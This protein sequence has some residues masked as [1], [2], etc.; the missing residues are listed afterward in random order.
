MAFSSWPSP[1]IRSRLDP[2]LEAELKQIRSDGFARDAEEHEAGIKCLGAPILDREGTIVAALSA[3]WPLF[4]YE[5]GKEA[6][7]AAAI[8]AAAGRVS[9]LLG[10]EGPGLAEDR[11][12]PTP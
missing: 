12:T 3:S 2:E 5:A 7:S 11:L 9:A 6:R 1:R 8:V 10:Y 4:R